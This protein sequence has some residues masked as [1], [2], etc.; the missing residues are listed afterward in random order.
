M[1]WLRR[2]GS[3]GRGAEAR[4]AG[5]AAAALTLAADRYNVF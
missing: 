4:P 3:P 2:G 1:S 5:V